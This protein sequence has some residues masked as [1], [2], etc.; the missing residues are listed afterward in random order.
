MPLS[1]Q[2]AVKRINEQVTV[3]MLVKAAKN[4]QHC[5]QIFLD[6]EVD[7]HEPNNLAVAVTKTGK[8]R[9]AEAQIDDPAGHFKGKTIR[10]TGTVV[11]KENRPNIEVDDPAQI[12]V[13]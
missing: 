1:P 11:I 2:E 10:V 9:F 6:S 3:E 7:H 12:E 5:S 8:A 4:C 13:V